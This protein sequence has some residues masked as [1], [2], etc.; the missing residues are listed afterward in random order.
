MLFIQSPGT[1]ALCPRIL[2]RVPSILI[3]DTG[4]TGRFGMHQLV[5]RFMRN[6]IDAGCT[7]VHGGEGNATLR[8][9]Q[10]NA[11]CTGTHNGH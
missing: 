4:M 7:G 11:S 10:R 1:R 8:R 9:M 6:G 3:Q 2:L 5:H